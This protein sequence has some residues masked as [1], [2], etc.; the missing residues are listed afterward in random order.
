MHGGARAPGQGAASAEL[1]AWPWWRGGAFTRLRC[2]QESSLRLQRVGLGLRRGHL[3][4]HVQEPAAEGKG[5]ARAVGQGDLVP[6]PHDGEQDVGHAAAAVDDAV[7]ERVHVLEHQ[8]VHLVVH[9]VHHAVEGEDTQGRVGLRGLEGPREGEHLAPL[10][11][12]GRGQQ[13]SEAQAVHVHK[14]VGPVHHAGAKVLAHELG[15]DGAGGEAHVGAQGEGE[16]QEGGRGLRHGGDAHA[17]HD[18][19]QRERHAQRNGLIAQKGEGEEHR[20]DG[21]ARLDRVH[22]GGVHRAEGGVGEAEAQ[23]VHEAEH[24]QRRAR[25]RRERRGGWHGLVS[26]Q[27]EHAVGHGAQGGGRE[28]LDHG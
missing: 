1:G 26:A 24:R 19:Q 6:E 23:G 16:P 25:A 12:Q 5:D 7:R 22:E 18:G 2:H 21:L 10:E 15:G 17:T 3:G 28:V 8:E 27:A 11:G 4:A 20:G 13:Q 14:E 9:V